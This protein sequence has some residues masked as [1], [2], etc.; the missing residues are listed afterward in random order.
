LTYKEKIGLKSEIE[1][2]YREVH[3]SDCAEPPGEEAGKAIFVR[4]WNCRN[5]K[6]APLYLLM[7]AS[8]PSPVVV[9][10]VG[11]EDGVKSIA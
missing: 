8:S 4:A 1:D 5:E 3:R 6:D 2:G 9:K 11:N 10:V 7:R